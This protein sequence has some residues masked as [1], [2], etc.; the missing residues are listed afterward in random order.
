MVLLME[1][2]QAPIVP[3]N[4]N[5]T[6]HMF[7]KGWGKLSVVIGKPIS[8]EMLNAPEGVNNRREWIAERIMAGLVITPIPERLDGALFG[9]RVIERTRRLRR[10]ENDF[11]ANPEL[12]ALVVDMMEEMA[13]LRRQARHSHP[14]I[15]IL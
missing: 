8:A 10:I 13:L 2:S 11:D 15:D 4:V 7:T 6:K 12:A 3:I 5:G 9:S 1:K 14:A